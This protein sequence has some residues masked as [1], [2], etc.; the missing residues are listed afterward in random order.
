V[1]AA[2]EHANT[3]QGAVGAATQLLDQAARYLWRRA[4][5]RAALAAKQQALAIEEVVYGPD[6]LQVAKSLGNLGIVRKD[7]GDLAG[8]RAAQERALAIKQ[9]AG[10]SG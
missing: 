3:H 2:A 1:L 7:L 6:H 9:A 5:L 10:P 4:D 8:A